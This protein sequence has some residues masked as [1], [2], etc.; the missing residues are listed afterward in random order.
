VARPFWQELRQRRVYKAAA[1][2]AVAAFALWQAADIAV[3]AL[4]YPEAIMRYIVA[5]ALVG[6]PVVLL[7]SWLYDFTITRAEPRAVTHSKPR[8]GRL[9]VGLVTLLLSAGLVGWVLV[10]AARRAERSA[11]AVSLELAI[12]EFFAGDRPRAIGHLESILANPAVAIKRRQEAARYLVRTYSELGDSSLARATMHRLLDLEPPLALMVPVVETESV[13][14]LYYEVRQ[15]KLTRGRLAGTDSAMDAIMV[16]DLI[17]RGDPPPG[18]EPVDWRTIGHGIRQ[19]LMVEL[20]QRLNGDVAIT[21]G[22][23]SDRSRGYDMYRYL[24]SPEAAR[25]RKPSHIVI[26]SVAAR[27]NNVLISAWLIDAINGALSRSGQTLGDREDLF[28]LVV[29]LAAQ[30]AG[31]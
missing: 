27:G 3:P 6:F 8:T 29:R 2:Y 25:I 23:I 12:E 14:R 24:D 20:H 4:G 19:M 11:L 21:E 17:V 16:F 7:I 9:A 15:D 13:M 30:L 1:V 31:G 10:T 18:V 5:G 22:G 28:D 26:G